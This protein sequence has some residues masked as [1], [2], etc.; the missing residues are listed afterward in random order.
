MDLADLE[1]LSETTTFGLFL[2][3]LF[4][5]IV[6]DLPSQGR[7]GDGDRVRGRVLSVLGLTLAV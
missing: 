1:D 4:G 2:G 7:V 3:S 6:G 5:L